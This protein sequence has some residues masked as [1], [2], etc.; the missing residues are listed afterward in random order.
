M[1]T[2]SN[3]IEHLKDNYNLQ[4]YDE[5]EVRNMFR[6]M[7]DDIHETVKIGSLEYAPSYVLEEVD[8]IAFNQGWL[9]YVDAEEMDEY[10]EYYTRKEDL[11]EKIEE[12]LKDEEGDDSFLEIA[13]KVKVL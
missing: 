11:Q 7:L 6:D 3:L 1:K 2:V 10:G 5:C 13:N 12:Y 8:P 9:E 4:A